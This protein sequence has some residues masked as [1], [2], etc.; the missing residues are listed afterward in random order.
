MTNAL[1]GSVERAVWEIR[2]FRPKPNNPVILSPDP[3]GTKDPGI[4][5]RFVRY[6]HP[7]QSAMRGFFALKY[8]LRMT[9]AFVGSK[10]RTISRAAKRWR[11]WARH[12]LPKH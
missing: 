3:I 8:G 4:I 12:P 11:Y 2:C 10:E 7:E 5:Q 6:A 9:I 1:V